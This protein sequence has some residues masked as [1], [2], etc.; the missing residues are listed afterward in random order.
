MV[1]ETVLPMDIESG[2]YLC[3]RSA[4]Q[5]MKFYV[6]GQIRKEYSTK[7]SRLFGRLS[8]VAYVFVN[9]REGDAGKTLRVEMST[10]SSYT[11]VLYTVYYGNPM[12]M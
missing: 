7:E 3:F 6:D 10:D 5:D 2:R 8:A 4:K 1:V 9:I 11:G 12:G